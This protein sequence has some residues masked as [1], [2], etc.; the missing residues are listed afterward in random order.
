MT[1]VTHLKQILINQPKIKI[2]TFNF[3][4]MTK[5]GTWELLGDL[6]TPGQI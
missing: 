5:W 2:F 6:P 1:M 3:K 4:N